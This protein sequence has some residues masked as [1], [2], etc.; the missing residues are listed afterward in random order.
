M[1]YGKTCNKDLNF[2]GVF[3]WKKF[4]LYRL[5]R[6][7]IRLRLSQNSENGKIVR[8]GRPS[9]PS[10]PTGRRFGRLQIPSYSNSFSNLCVDI[11]EEISTDNNRIEFLSGRQRKQICCFQN[12]CLFGNLISIFAKSAAFKV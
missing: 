12:S 1:V 10:A 3:D 9:E 6:L 5:G 8:F 2:K 11:G 4:N 7:R